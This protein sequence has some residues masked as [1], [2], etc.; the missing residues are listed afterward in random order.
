M[1]SQNS[2][3]NTFFIHKKKTK[4]RIFKIILSLVFLLFCRIGTTFA[5]HQDDEVSTYLNHA[6]D[7]A[8]LYR[9][10]MLD[11]SYVGWQTHPYWGDG[12][13]VK[14]SVRFNGVDYPNV[15]LRYNIYTQQ[16]EVRTPITQ[17]VVLP[18]QDKITQFTIGGK[19]YIHRKVGYSAI[20]YQGQEFTIENKIRKIR[21]KDNT[22]GLYSQKVL[23][24]TVETFLRTSQGEQH[25]KSLND[26]KKCFPQ[27]KDDINTYKALTK[28]EATK[29]EKII[30]IASCAAY[31]EKTA[32]KRGESTI[33]YLKIKENKKQKTLIQE[34]KGNGHSSQ[35]T[36]VSQNIILPD[37]LCIVI[38][39][40]Q[41]EGVNLASE[42]FETFRDGAPISIKKASER[43]IARN[44]TGISELK[45]D[46]EI[47]TLDELEITAFRSN[48]GLVQMGAEKFRPQQLRNVPMAMGESDVMK[49]VQTMPGIKTMGE[50]SS[51]FNVR[52]GAA[53]QNLIL[54]SGNTIYNPM[55]M[56]GL[57]SAF[58]SDALNDVEIFKGS[59]P[60]QYGGRISSV[61]NISSRQADKKHF[62]GS[63]SVGLLTSKAHL[64]I[65]ILKNKLSWL[66]AGRTTYSDWMLKMLPK[67]KSEYS[68]GKAGF[69]DLTSTLSWNLSKNQFI[70]ISG[71]Y[72]HDRF[73]LTRY[74]A[75]G[76]T[77]GN[78]SMEWKSYWTDQ[79]TSVITTGYDHYDY[80]NDDKSVKGSASRLSFAIDQKFLRAHFQL[81]T[82]DQ[83]TLR[84]GV[85]TLLYSIVPG[86]LEALGAFSYIK[87]YELPTQSAIEA[88]VYTEDE[89]H[90]TEKW[91][92]LGGMRLNLFNTSC[93]GKEKA[94][95]RPEIRTSAMYMIN[96]N[97]SFKLGFNTMNQFIHKVSNT[98]IMSPTDTWTLSNKYIR[99]QQGWQLSTG[100]SG[101]TNNGLLELTAELY[102]KHMKNYLTYRSGAQLTMNSE[103]EKDVVGAEGKAYGLEVQLKK[104]TG[105][106]NGWISYSYSRTFLKQQDRTGVNTINEGTWYPAEYDRPHELN[107]VAN[108]KFTRRYSLSLNMDYATGRP[109]T[110]PAGK[111]FN[112]Q[113]NCY[114]PF[115]AERNSYRLPDKFRI[116]LSFNIEPSHHLTSKTHSWFS[117]GVY[118]LLGR[119]NVYNVYY[120]MEGSSLKGYSLSI[121]GCPIPFVSYNIKF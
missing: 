18:E 83:N 30:E 21:V 23:K 24:T 46:K 73:S 95:F 12:Q 3:H 36:E 61:M 26:L 56:F 50:A 29:K 85:N 68:G 109:T 32:N 5:Q 88:T 38:S 93:D 103:I 19:K 49:M 74:N 62:A 20:E 25:I 118:N 11:Q 100:Y 16:L 2:V 64:E 40:K 60:C 53:D 105:K 42:V 102:Y 111:Y 121:F 92:L 59:I 45:P 52:G 9:G 69:Y 17:L 115:Y 39:S 1:S 28:D 63:A 44:N 91:T 14:G 104:L 106:L 43:N 117:M 65:P 6:Q 35:N 94:Y 119:K 31:L 57:F 77:N 110:V 34:L 120:K 99:P 55:H 78:I 4:I 96:E 112:T 75:Y 41:S 116:D 87:P 51:G 70:N 54:L 22:E 113:Q 76:Y 67:S 82:S 90:P 48:V 66:F 80:R 7:Y 114:L 81:H 33:P 107:I 97:Q 13:F 98:L 58:N 72:S 108:Y 8:A 101:K 86:R 10:I 79:L 89:V 37:S 71:Y 27:Q 15:S 84:F 47:R